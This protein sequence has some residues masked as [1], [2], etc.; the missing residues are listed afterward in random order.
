MKKYIIAISAAA[1]AFA[2]CTV[3]EEFVPA[4]E[5]VI[6][7]VEAFS[8]PELKTSLGEKTGNS[9]P[10]YWNAGDGIII[11]GIGSQALGEVGEHCTSASFTFDSPISEPYS[12]GYP[13]YS[14]TDY[15]DTSAT[16]I[17][18]ST[19]RYVAGSFDPDAAIM[20]GKGDAASGIHFTTP[21]A[22]MRITVNAKEGGDS[23]GIS[24]I[25]L[26]S[27]DGEPLSGNLYT[28]FETLRPMEGGAPEIT[29]SAAPAIPLGTG[30]IVAVP[31]QTYVHGLIIKV[32]DE[33]GHIMS[34]RSADSCKVQ[35]GHIYN[36]EFTFEPTGSNDKVGIY[37]E[38]DLIAFL[39]EA[40]GLVEC[41]N[42]YE[43]T[44][45][46]DTI[47]TG[48]IARW[49]DPAD[50][51][52]H[53]YNDIT[54]TK[55][56]NWSGQTPGERYCSVSNF[57]KNWVLNGEGHTITGEFYTP[58]FIN[59]YG[60]VKKLK[61]AG[62]MSD[63][64]TCELAS[65]L[66]CTVQEGGLIEEVENHVAITG[67]FP[68]GLTGSMRS[69]YM[70]G[71]AY[72][73]APGGTIRNCN[74]YG[75]I[76]DGGKPLGVIA[77]IVS[78]NKG[79]VEGCHNYGTLSINYTNPCGGI[80][81][82]QYGGEIKNC[83]NEAA[84]GSTYHQS[85]FA[86]ICYQVEGGDILGCTNNGNITQNIDVTSAGGLTYSG[87]IIAVVGPR[88][89]KTSGNYATVPQDTLKGMINIV[90]CVN[91]G[92]ISFT[93]SGTAN[94]PTQASS[95]GGIAAWINV[96][97]TPEAY[98]Y[99]KD[100]A[101]HGTITMRSE[102]ITGSMF[103][104]VGGII[105]QAGPYGTTSSN[106]T[107]P[108]VPGMPDG[109]MQAGE[110][111]DGSYF[112]IE[113]CSNDATIDAKT[114]LGNDAG[115]YALVW[116]S[117]TG[118]IAGIITGSNDHHADIINCSNTGSVVAGCYQ[119]SGN[120][121][122]FIQINGTSGGKGLAPVRAARIVNIGGIAGIGSFVNITGCSVNGTIGS[123]DQYFAHSTGGAIGAAFGR[124]NI[125]GGNYDVTVY[126]SNWYKDKWFGLAV[127]YGSSNDS[128]IARTD[129]SYLSG[130]C[131]KNINVKGFLC[132][133]PWVTGGT[134]YSYSDVH[135]GNFESMLMSE[136]DN[137]KNAS[138]SWCII[139][140]NTW[141]GTTRNTSNVKTL[142]FDFDLSANPYGWPTANNTGEQTWSMVAAE[143]G[144]SYEF[145]RHGG[146]LGSLNGVYYFVLQ[147]R[148]LGFPVIENWTL[149]RAIVTLG[150]NGS[151]RNFG[152]S[153]VDALE[154]TSYSP[155][156]MEGGSLLIIPAGQAG[157]FVRHLFNSE[158]GTR[159]WA[160]GNTLVIK[161]L[162]LTY[163]EE[164]Q[165]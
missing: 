62:I 47:A 163:V 27:V 93:I 46:S 111:A 128:N 63:Q 98:V 11:N 33:Q 129:M 28:D 141:T 72:K 88:T 108:S 124:F 160:F 102:V 37:D 15:T 69:R 42:W 117:G 96:R 110:Q 12:A 92:N 127:G 76:S 122:S 49:I 55:R 109:K 107:P 116:Q 133:D 32:T 139:S 21:M 70:G 89:F 156:Y 61:L 45:W 112:K 87:G 39:N 95:L 10:V 161:E 40:D 148:Y 34:K 147:G 35:A 80:C 115:S 52:V 121:G 149:V 114:I 29:L 113:N 3:K 65:P 101:N 84:L 24:S 105:G 159:Y 82:T 66:A 31:A 16:A 94:R 99:V 90:N 103:P 140:G 132:N 23:H 18:P 86:G 74:N 26:T 2:A 138:T 1:L 20:V 17:L 58:I 64:R 144:N 164:P 130:S 120:R 57:A 53:I 153:S 7:T 123:R 73:A 145:A 152:V 83:T 36:V 78:L 157:P 143:D 67:N 131:I 25:K 75:T 135:A 146:Y 41:P 154:G 125:E 136:K 60:T 48:S 97:T 5:K 6:T 158:P 8:A 22:Y 85:R 43:E 106:T 14:F 151:K 155:V 119:S 165:P 150:N 51:E 59:L 162:K 100:C 91:N 134:D 50:G 4:G 19:Q 142:T 81:F 71:I 118:G 137:T 13:S 126:N 44:A 68:E 79:T 54:L 77:G 30:A 38:A 9:Y 104:G 56:V